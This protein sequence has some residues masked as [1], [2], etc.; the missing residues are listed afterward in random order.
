[1]AVT[2]IDGVLYVDNTIMSTLATCPLKA[3]ISYGLDRRPATSE[4]ANL[5]MGKA[6]HAALETYLV[7]GTDEECVEVLKKEYEDFARG[8]LYDNKRLG[9][10]NIELVLRS[11]LQ[12]N[13]QERWPFRVDPKNIEIGFGVPLDETGDIIFTGRI[14][15]LAHAKYGDTLF[16][17]DHKCSG[18]VDKRK[19]VMAPQMTGY[20]WAMEQLGHHVDGIYINAVHAGQVPTS[21]RKCTTHKTF[22]NECGFLHMKHELIGPFHRSPEELETWRLDTLAFAREWKELLD[23]VDGDLN[24]LKHIKQKGKWIYQ[25]C[26]MCPWLDYCRSGQQVHWIENNTIV[27]PWKPGV[28]ADL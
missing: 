14:D 11:W 16:A 8:N 27:D 1:M 26:S 10:E 7:G 18:T 24:K 20:L 2:Y 12:K 21:N 22:Y 9:Y 3:M 17:M 28:V 15:V 23:Y 25:A 19:Y 4:N 6:I 13:P 5:M